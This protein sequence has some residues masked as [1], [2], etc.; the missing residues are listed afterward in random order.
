MKVTDLGHILAR[1]CSL[2]TFDVQAKD[3]LCC[4][5]YNICF[6]SVCVPV[7]VAIVTASEFVFSIVADVMCLPSFPFIL[8]AETVL[9]T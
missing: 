9:T 6:V 3:V 7:Y 1:S 2:V 4:F 5:G 8:E